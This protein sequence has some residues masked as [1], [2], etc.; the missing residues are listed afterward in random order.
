[1]T[2]VWHAGAPED[3]RIVIGFA[4]SDPEV[5]ANP[6]PPS[7]FLTASFLIYWQA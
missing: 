1:M 2:K 5:P 4:V 3:A 6:R 7:E